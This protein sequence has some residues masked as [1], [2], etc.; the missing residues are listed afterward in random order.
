M[1]LISNNSTYS[2]NIIHTPSQNI[3][4]SYQPDIQIF[5]DM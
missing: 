1:D 5:E 3:I 4:A 2:Q